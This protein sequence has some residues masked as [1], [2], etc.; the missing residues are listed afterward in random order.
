[1]IKL[2]DRIILCNMTKLLLLLIY[3]IVIG[4]SLGAGVA[5]LLGILLRPEYPNLRVY[6]FS[7][8]GNVLRC[9]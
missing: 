3:E 4:H 5:V 2:D 6:A 1:M 9:L 8:P 7:T